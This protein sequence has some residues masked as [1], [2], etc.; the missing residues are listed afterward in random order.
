MLSIYANKNEL[1]IDGEYISGVVYSTSGAAVMNLD[2][3]AVTS[4]SSLSD[5]IYIVKVTKADGKVMTAK[6][7]K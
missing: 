2:G 5:G 7:T 6:I 1:H 3:A 4:L